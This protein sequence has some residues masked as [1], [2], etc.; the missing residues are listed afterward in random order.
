MNKLDLTNKENVIEVL[1]NKGL[2]D[3]IPT[4]TDRDWLWVL[5]YIIT[6][7]YNRELLRGFNISTTWDGL[8]ERYS[9]MAVNILYGNLYDSPF[10]EICGSFGLCSDRCLVDVY[11]EECLVGLDK[12]LCDRVRCF[13]VLE[14]ISFLWSVSGLRVVYCGSDFGY[15]DYRVDMVDG[16]GFVSSFMVSRVRCGGDKSYVRS[17]VF[18]G[19]VRYCDGRF[20]GELVSEVADLLGEMVSDLISFMGC[21]GDKVV[22][23]FGGDV[24]Y[25]V[26]AY[27]CAREIVVSDIEV[28]GEYGV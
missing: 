9:V 20:G 28:V 10:D 6:Y 24:V 5:D 27:R 17:S 23:G 13:E 12:C 26:N 1:K 14:E 22:V 19:L 7:L 15:S 18:S 8:L 16:Y 2:N 3:F 21:Y 11:F 25:D 4:D